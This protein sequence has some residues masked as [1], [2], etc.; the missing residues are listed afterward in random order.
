MAKK[1]EKPLQTNEET[2]D[3]VLTIDIG[4]VNTRVSLFERENGRYQFTGTASN[5]T[6]YSDSGEVEYQ[7]IS[8]A[9]QKLESALER[10][11]L[12]DTGKIVIPA[13]YK[14]AWHRNAGIPLVW[15][16]GAGHNANTDAPERV[17]ELI[18]GLWQRVRGRA[19]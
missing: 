19:P 6:V 8:G 9:V 1:Q 3:I 16:E 12:D 5:R 4:T 2:V 15:I 7:S 17:N 18:E 10:H 11:F 14:K 13:R